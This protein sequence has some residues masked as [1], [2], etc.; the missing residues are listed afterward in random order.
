MAELSRD[1]LSQ[2]IAAIAEMERQALHQ[3]TKAD[4]M[5][6]AITH[7][8]GSMVFAVAHVAWFGAWILINVGMIPGVEPFDPFPFGLLTLVVSLEAIFLTVFVLMSQSRMT[9]LSEKRA[10]LDL[11]LD[12]LEE[13]ELTAIL[14]MLRALCKKHGVEVPQHDLH[15]EELMKHTDVKHMAVALD[16]G[17]QNGR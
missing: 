17:L 3:R 15:I 14:R 12:L 8:T 4:R 7:A 6:D 1:L 10:H 11:Q 13:Q 5:G 9:R 2:N 16:D